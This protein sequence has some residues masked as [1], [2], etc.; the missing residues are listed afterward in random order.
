M[1]QMIPSVANRRSQSYFM[2]AV[3][4]LGIFF[5]PLAAWPQ[6]AARGPKRYISLQPHDPDGIGKFYMGREIAQIMGHEAADWL[7]RPERVAEEQPDALVSRLSLRRGEVVADIGAG[8]GYFSRRLAQAVG[9]TGRVLAED[10]QPEM[11]ALLKGLAARL[12]LT[13]ITPVL[14]SIT[15]PLLPAASVDLVLMVDVYHEFDFPYEMMQAICGALKP[16]G[17]VVFVEYRGEDP[18]VPIKA[19]H[20][21][22]QAQVKREMSVMPL[23]WIRTI[24]DFPRQHIIIFRK[25]ATGMPGASTAAPLR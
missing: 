1:Q 19:L 5:L 7:E 9:L 23:D 24:E 18:T 12:A 3:F 16:G 20:K 2:V 13:N 14:G 11:I 6:Q 25:R 10:V 4:G 21:M 17:R 22:T 15:N 8:T